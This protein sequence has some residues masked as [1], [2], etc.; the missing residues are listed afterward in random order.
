MNILMI[1]AFDLVVSR[2]WGPTVRLHS[3]AKE[4]I[5]MH[6]TVTLAGP[7][8]FSGS[9]PALLDG[10]SLYY[11]RMAFHRYGYADD[12]KLPERKQHNRLWRLPLV[13]LTR[14]CE[15]VRLVL[16]LKPDVLYINRAFIDIL[17]PS[18]FTHL[19]TR[20]PLVCDWDDLEGL[21]GFST[22][23]QFP[24]RIQLFET[25][26]E[27]LLPRLADAT[28]VASRYLEE[29]ALNIGV[30]RDRLFYAPTVANAE[31]FHPDVDG[32]AVRER[33][34][35]QGRKVMLYCGNL[36][37]G[38][39][40]KVEN[41]LYALHYLLQRD[42]SYYLVVVGE[43]DLLQK[44]GQPG[45]L[46]LLA[47]NLG[48]SSHVIFTGGVPTTEVPKYIAAADACLALFPV[49]L[50]TI[51]KSPLKVYEY[52]A[53]GKA[54]IARDVGEISGCVISGK[55]GI[56]VHTDNPEEYAQRIYDCFSK[57]GALLELGANAR[58]TIEEHF[59]WEHSARTVLE[60]CE[61]AR[62]KNRSQSRSV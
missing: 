30:K 47:E 24:L 19:I 12:G 58:L 55:T 23:F 27:L 49:N 9:Q 43:G 14:T 32:S 60:A 21:H 4:L 54:T 36:F 53:S 7:A 1:S 20:V 46:P 17:Y 44:G 25:I 8:P 37:A 15:L 57:N 48:I 38:N 52:M 28:V 3:L 18:Y 11:F 29:F 26:H 22:N 50:T 16:K 39:G 61:R 35:L 5:Y 42:S 2:L 59:L 31:L 6:H 41:T 13:M 56:L 34:G 62:G 51:T 10:V 40:V 45:A 33:Y